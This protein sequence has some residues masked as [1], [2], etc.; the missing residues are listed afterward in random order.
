MLV[1]VERKKRKSKVKL[2]WDDTSR[3][4]ILSSLGLMVVEAVA[5]LAL[6]G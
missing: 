2:T 1:Q 6:M 4:P 5:I 3:A